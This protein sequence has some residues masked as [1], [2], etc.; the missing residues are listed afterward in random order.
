VQGVAG[1]VFEL[2]LGNGR[3][4]D[5]LRQLFPARPIY[6]CER[7][8]AAH[9]LCIPPP[10]RL[11]LGDMRQTLPEL[12][13]RFAGRVAL[14]HLDPGSGDIAESRALA[15]ALGPLIMPLLAEEAVL[16]S[17][18]ALALEGLLP[19]DLPAGVEPGR[20]HLYRRVGNR[21]RS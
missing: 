17:E 13:G 14:A 19:L 8:V 18:P 7:A 5:H 1:D 16:V 21:D 12:C 3:T 9:P 15:L 4:Y 10:D 6:V 20:Y 2:G 11:F